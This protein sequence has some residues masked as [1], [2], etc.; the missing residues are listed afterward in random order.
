MVFA[1]A[2]QRY[3]HFSYSRGKKKE[4][5]ANMASTMAKPPFGLVVFFCLAAPAASVPTP[6][7]ART[8][9]SLDAGA[10]AAV[11]GGCP[12]RRAVALAQQLTSSSRCAGTATLS[13]PSGLAD[14]V[15]T[16]Y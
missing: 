3:M 11:D 5:F 2:Q 13:L 10:S 1:R 8:A 4:N 6:T 15:L 12:A 9:A 16:K 7:Y 14:F